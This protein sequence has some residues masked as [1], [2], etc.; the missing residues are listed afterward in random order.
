MKKGKVAV[1]GLA[2]QSVFLKEDHFPVPG[3]T[4]SC[5]GLFFEWALKL[6]LL[7]L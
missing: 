3:E 2:G 7:V 6:C 1:I 4:V 5:S